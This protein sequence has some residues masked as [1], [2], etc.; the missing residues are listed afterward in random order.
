MYLVTLINNNEET[1][2]HGVWQKLRSGNVVKGINVIDSF[3][4]SLLPSSAGFEKINDM[5]TLV[6]VYNTNKQR[7][8]FFGRVLYSASTMEESGLIYKNVV[9]ESYLGFLCDSQQAYVDTTN[10]TVKGLLQHIINKHNAQVESYKQF[11]LGNV[12]MTPNENVYI[13]IQRDN[14][15][16]VI[17][18]KLLN[19]VGGEISF[20]VS[21]G[22]N[23]IDYVEKRGSTLSTEIKV[24]K[25]MKSITREDNPM[26]YV[27]R[28]IP[29]GAKIKITD[30]DGNN[31]DTEER[32]GISSVNNGL[33]YI[34]SAEAKALYGIRYA[35]VIFDDVNTASNLLSKAQTYL[36]TNNKVQIKYTINALDLSLLGLDIDDFEVCNFHPI[37]NHLL[38][39]DDTARIIKKNIDVCREVGSSVEFGENYKTLSS[40]NKENSNSIK[41]FFNR[42]DNI[43]NEI[44]DGVFEGIDDEMN[45]IRT[46]ITEQYTRV[47]S[48]CESIIMSALVSYTQTGDFESFKTTVESQLQLL[49]DEMTLK[50]TEATQQIQDVNGELQGQLNTITKY[51]TFNMDGLTIGQSDS[52]YKVIIDNDRY[53]MTVNDV[54]VMWIADGKVYTPEVEVT[55]SFKLFGYLIEQDD[56]GRVNCAYVGGE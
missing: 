34:E 6:R 46:E 9:C 8:E 24:S 53:S 42:L 29:L 40:L 12:T 14:S 10:W 52:P 44:K 54:E 27:S 48:D 39:I 49:A 25:N 3:S 35:T 17:E 20:R 1:Q 41:D 23:Y 15:W 5:K 22:V 33:D 50:F 47:T 45:L 13:G 30:Q 2:I 43:K 28:L 38:G 31:V 51:F 26:N 18:D 11:T 4:F 16:K 19:K 56:A 7:D 21:N 36:A 55:K 37:K 32:V